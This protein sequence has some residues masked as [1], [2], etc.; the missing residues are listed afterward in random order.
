LPQDSLVVHNGRSPSFFDPDLPKEGA[1]LCAGRLWDAGKQVA[2]L[3]EAGLAAPVW[4]AGDGAGDR[5]RPGRC[6]GVR[7]YGLLAE[8]E[9]RGLFARAGI[10]AATSCYEP[11]G[12]APL[13]AALSRCAIVAND[14]PSLRELWGENVLYFRRNDANALR[15]AIARLRSDE[16]MRLE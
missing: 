13:E 12:L 1:V 5:L 15:E 16:A 11:F 3:L 7:F 8:S 6:S 2:L 14:I 10:Y 4:I 9:M